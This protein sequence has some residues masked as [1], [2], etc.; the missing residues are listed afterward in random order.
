MQHGRVATV[1]PSG[2]RRRRCFSQRKPHDERAAPIGTRASR[3][4]CAS[5]QH[6]ER[7]RDGQT[8]P[9]PTLPPIQSTLPLHEQVERTRHQIRGHADPVVA[10][11]DH[12]IPLLLAGA[13]QDVTVGLGILRR[14]RQQVG[15]HLRDPDPVG[16]DHQSSGD[17]YLQVV[18]LVGHHRRR[19]LDRARNGV[20]EIESFAPQ[21]DGASLEARDVQQVVDEP[22]HVPDLP[23]QNLAL[24]RRIVGAAQLHQVKGGQRWRERVAQLVT[25]HREELILAAIGRFGLR[26]RRVGAGDLLVPL[27]LPRVEKRGRSGEG[28]QQALDLGHRRLRPRRP[29]SAG[30]CFGLRR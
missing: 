14:V 7:A 17:V 22:G 25:K 15:Q 27:L 5:V 16:V 10:A 19:H 24:P 29:Q 4:D 23:L 18:M 28:V 11:L 20:D 1:L 9:Q 8:Q 30:D 12:D 21:I 26:A 2:V 6:H 3:L 13:H